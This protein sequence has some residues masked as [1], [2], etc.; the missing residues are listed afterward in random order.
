MGNLGRS[1]FLIIIALVFLLLIVLP[2]LNRKSSS[3]SDSDRALRTKQSL[4][5]VETAQQQ[6]FA[7]NGRYTDHI[8]DLIPLAPKLATD[9]TDGIV[10]I[11]IDSSGGKNYL[12]QVA[13]PVVSFTRAYVGGQLTAKSCL[14]L[15]SAGSDFCKR[16]TSDIVK[17]LPVTTTPAGTVPAP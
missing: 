1:P 2:L 9:L 7:K 6:Y 5:R 13:S 8:S 3:V 4:T 11:Q 17:S 14:Q 16:K 10:T 12:V 15:K